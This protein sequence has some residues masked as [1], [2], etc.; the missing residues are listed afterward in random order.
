MKSAHAT[1]FHIC[2]NSSLQ[3]C[4]SLS[5]PLLL[6]GGDPC[7]KLD[8]ATV[9]VILLLPLGQAGDLSADAR[10]ASAGEYDDDA[11]FADCIQDG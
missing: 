10:G 2:L 6:F 5:L 3:T 4:T 11:L 1:S 7:H 8:V 9:S